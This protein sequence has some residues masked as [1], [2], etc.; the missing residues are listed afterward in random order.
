MY[1]TH[2]YVKLPCPQ[3][4]LRKP[5]AEILG[6]IKQRPIMQTRGEVQVFN[7]KVVNVAITGAE[8]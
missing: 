3:L 5:T 8:K 1:K 7:K 4:Y 2:K 6:L